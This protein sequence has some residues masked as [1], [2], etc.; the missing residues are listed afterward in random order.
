MG[1]TSKLNFKTMPRFNDAVGY[2]GELSNEV[3]EKSF[4]MLC[5]LAVTGKTNLTPVDIQTLTALYRGDA[6]YTG[7]TTPPSP[8][9][10]APTASTDA[11]E[12]DSSF[13]HF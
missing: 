6:S 2:L 10:P 9:L 3:N 12:E 4:T 8:P 11:L 13:S 7:L 5:D 1:P